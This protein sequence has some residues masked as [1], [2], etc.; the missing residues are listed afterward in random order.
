MNRSTLKQT[1]MD[2]FLK[3]RSEAANQP[4]DDSQA[5][6]S[7]YI[8]SEPELDQLDPQESDPEAA[9][10]DNDPLDDGLMD[11][12]MSEPEQEAAEA[13]ALLPAAAATPSQTA[14]GLKRK[15]KEP[16]QYVAVLL[17]PMLIILVSKSLRCSCLS[18]SPTTASQSKSCS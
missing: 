2:G 15:A 12:I 10:N 1:T 7:Q 11:E 16:D 14:P 3:K 18:L 6:G 8:I 13:P 4:E 17:R 5:S 9:L